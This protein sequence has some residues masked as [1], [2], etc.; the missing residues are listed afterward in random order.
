MARQ[1]KRCVLSQRSSN[2]HN[3]AN[4]NGHFRQM[5]EKRVSSGC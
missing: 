4:L 3:F 2:G 5:L 1:R